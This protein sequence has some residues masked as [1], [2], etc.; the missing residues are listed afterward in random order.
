MFE[1]VLRARILLLAWCKGSPGR[2]SVVVAFRMSLD[3]KYRLASPWIVPVLF[4]LPMLFPLC[5][6][7]VCPFGCD[8]L[9]EELW[10]VILSLSCPGDSF[11]LWLTMC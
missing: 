4:G 5:S 7:V 6:G 8:G 2:Y 1:I 11:G 9:I 10:L 3:L